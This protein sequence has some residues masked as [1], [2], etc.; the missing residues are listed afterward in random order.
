MSAESIQVEGLSDLMRSLGSLESDL[1]REIRLELR[2]IVGSVATEA[3]RIAES[4]GLKS[5]D[6]GRQNTTLIDGIKPSV[7]GSVGYVREVAV[8]T[9]GLGAP[10]SYP[11]LYEYA[12]DRSFMRTALEHKHVDAEAR[13]NRMLGRLV[14]GHGL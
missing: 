7:R 9:I 2:E 6:P 11:R 12:R 8:R 3:R 5:P 14:H 4:L 1:P 13:V 10:Y